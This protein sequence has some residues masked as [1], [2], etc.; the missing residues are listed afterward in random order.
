[1]TLLDT[2]LSWLK[3]PAVYK[4]AITV[5]FVVHTSIIGL[6]A[7]AESLDDPVSEAIFDNFR[8]ITRPYTKKLFDQRQQWTMFSHPTNTSYKFII[9]T[10]DAQNVWS[11]HE[12]FSIRDYPML[13][14]YN[15]FKVARRL[16][17]TKSDKAGKRERFLQWYCRHHWIPY[18]TPI[19]MLRYYSKPPPYDDMKNAD[20]DNWER[21]WKTA[22][23]RQSSCPKW[24]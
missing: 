15:Y 16:M 8:P 6:H 10:Q 21:E 14:R 22:E 4:I 12:F 19:R 18:G 24:P 5:F 2:V 11:E 23:M 20:W 1:M 3:Q 13:T 17:T 9:E 7:L